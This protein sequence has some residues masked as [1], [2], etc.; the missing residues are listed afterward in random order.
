VATAHL[1]QVVA[2]TR[3]QIYGHPA[4]GPDGSIGALFDEI[5]SMLTPVASPNGVSLKVDCGDAAD[6]LVPTWVMR[7]V[8]VNLVANA[9]KYAPGSD[10]TLSARRCGSGVEISVADR[11]PGVP[12]EFIS[13]LTEPGFRMPHHQELPGDGLGLTV[14]RN[15]LATA[16]GSL[17]IRSD[18]MRTVVTASLPLAG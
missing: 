15:L 9:L 1:V 12:A 3:S 16:G 18:A 14:C 10:V 4:G 2:R 8:I 5:V 13:S 7:Q 17:A 11:G 6:A